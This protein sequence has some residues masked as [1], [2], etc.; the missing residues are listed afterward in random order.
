MIFSEVGSSGPLVS[1]KVAKSESARK[2]IS[3]T[4]AEAPA[5]DQVLEDT[6]EVLSECNKFSFVLGAFQ[7][8]RL[9]QRPYSAEMR[10]LIMLDKLQLA[11]IAGELFMGMKLDDTTTH[12]R[13][14][15][16][17]AR[18][19]VVD[20]KIKIHEIF[21]GYL[22][23]I[24]ALVEGLCNADSIV[25]RVNQNLEAALY[26]PDTMPGKAIMS[27]AKGS[28]SQL[29]ASTSGVPVKQDQKLKEP[30][31]ECDPDPKP[32]EQGDSDPS[33]KTQ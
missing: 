9:L 3:K 14:A 8:Y 2:R 20:T 33:A 31:P 11:C 25:S 32:D 15:S 17:E 18:Q 12:H 22:A 28:F 24:S 7:S 21:Q 30:D 27:K 1:D 26:S 4:M 6:M 23:D 29:S 16:D 13:N 10:M 19:K 5:P